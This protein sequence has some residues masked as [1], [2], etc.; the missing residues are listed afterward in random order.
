M[1][2]PQVICPG[3][4]GGA[5]SL[6][7][8][9]PD[10]HWFAGKYLVDPLPGGRLYFCSNCFLRFRYPVLSR[11]AYRHLYN[12]SSV[13]TWSSEKPRPDWEK[14]THYVHANVPAVGKVLDFGCYTGGLL[15]TLGVHYEKYGVEVNRSAATIAA[16]RSGAL[17]WQGLDEIPKGLR[18]DII[19]ATDVIEHVVNPQSLVARLVQLLNE[20]GTLII[21]TGDGDHYL[22]KFFD[23]NWWYCFFPEHLSFISRRWLQQFTKVSKT[24]VLYVENFYYSR[25]PAFRFVIDLGLGILYG[26]APDLYLRLAAIGKKAMH[27]AGGVV[28]RGVGLSADHLFVVLAKQKELQ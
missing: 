27:R 7:G 10:N 22:W 3:C 13:T 6:V 15:A 19:L 8:R 1:T 16:E 17:L 14:I 2:N 28:P 9:L 12:N 20:N 11:D 18:F 5:A 4:N 25:L 26:F 21:T 23:A 24:K